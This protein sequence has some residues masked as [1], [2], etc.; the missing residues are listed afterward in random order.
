M[1]FK[2]AR[3]EFFI[4]AGSSVAGLGAFSQGGG[5]PPQDSGTG[6]DTVRVLALFSYNG[7]IYYYNPAGLY[8]EVGQTVEWVGA[9]RRGVTAY[10]PSINDHELRIPEGAKP[11]DSE[12]MGSGGTLKWTFEVEGPYDYYSRA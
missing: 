3:R 4:L 2:I 5:L 12:T 6:S 10:H 7:G 1:S 11:F 9:G 8:I